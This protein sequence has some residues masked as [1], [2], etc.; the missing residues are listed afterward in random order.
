MKTTSVSLALTL[1]L[2]LLASSV[3]ADEKPKNKS[4]TTP[5]NPAA[6][7]KKEQPVEL[8]GSYI[9]RKVNRQGVVTDTAQAVVVI[10][11]TL[12]E[13]SGVSDLRQLL[14]RRGAR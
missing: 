6:E 11:R 4:A 1:T 2:S 5:S 10:D 7:V 8:T 9:K 14:T 12:I 3:L 13:Q